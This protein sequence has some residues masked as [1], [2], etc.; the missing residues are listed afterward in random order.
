MDAEISQQT[1]ILRSYY[2]IR[3]KKRMH[4]EFAKR[5]SGSEKE[6]KRTNLYTLVINRMVQNSE[7]KLPTSLIMEK[8]ADFLTVSPLEKA[9][10]NYFRVSAGLSFSN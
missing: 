8:E 3:D 7:G 5:S 10:V 6:S 1:P 9:L 4:I 2:Q